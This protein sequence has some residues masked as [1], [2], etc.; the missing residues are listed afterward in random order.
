M[1]ALT[2]VAALALQALLDELNALRTRHIERMASQQ[3]E[4]SMRVAAAEA[5]A[6]AVLA[7]ADRLDIFESA[8]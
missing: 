4:W 8:T 5:D 1:P 2:E 6:M 3:A 7:A